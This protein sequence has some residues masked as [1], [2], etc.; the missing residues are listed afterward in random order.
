MT[1]NPLR[2]AASLALAAL[3]AAA[4]ADMKPMHPMK[5]SVA[6]RRC[7]D[8]SFPIYFESGSDQ[9]T[10]VAKQ[11]ISSASN[12]VQGC[13]ITAVD[14][15]GLADAEGGAEANLELSR[16]RATTVASALAAAGLPAPAFDIQAAGAAGATTARGRPEPM[17]RRT[18]VVLHAVPAG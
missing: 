7:A 12:R 4:C 11:V 18:E 6:S 16:R 3:A 1:S 15:L 2:L 13:R 10:G 14:V 9:L 17:R 5:A 8:E